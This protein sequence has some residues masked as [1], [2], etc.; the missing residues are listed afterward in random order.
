VFDKRL[1]R[2]E[3]KHMAG[4]DLKNRLNTEYIYGE[5]VSVLDFNGDFEEILSDGRKK[6]DDVGRFSGSDTI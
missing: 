6:E 1:M 5:E 4:A 2:K 3:D